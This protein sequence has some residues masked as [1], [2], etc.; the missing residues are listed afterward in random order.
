MKWTGLGSGSVG[1]ICKC[2]HGS[3]KQKKWKCK[4]FI[5]APKYFKCFFELTVITLRLLLSVILLNVVVQIGDVCF[6][7]KYVY[8]FGKSFNT[9][10]SK[11]LAC[12]QILKSKLKAFSSS[13]FINLLAYLRKQ[14]FIYF[15]LACN[16]SISLELSLSKNVLPKNFY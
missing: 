2:S 4:I 7:K 3:G 1:D 8:I 13:L 12:M 11:Y 15:G 5:Q 6:R 10:Q 9:K 16:P 14:S